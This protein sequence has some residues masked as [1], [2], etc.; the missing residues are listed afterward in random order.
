MYGAEGSDIRKLFEEVLEESNVEVGYE[1]A[2]WS[3]RQ[4]DNVSD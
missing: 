1:S 2:L 4:S 3:D